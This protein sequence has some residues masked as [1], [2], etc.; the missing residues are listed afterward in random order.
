M[1]YAASS[2]ALAVLEMLVHVSRDYVPRHAVLVPLEI[3]DHLI[4]DLPLI[5]RKGGTAFPTNWMFDRP[6][7]AGWNNERSSLTR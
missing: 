7:T 5:S 1:V 6:A 4:V 3:P 2:R